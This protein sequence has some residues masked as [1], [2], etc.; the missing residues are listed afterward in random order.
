MLKKSFIIIITL[1]TCS[2]ALKAQEQ[3][4]DLSGNAHLNAL[5]NK[6]ITLK[7]PHIYKQP[8]A[9]NKILL[10]L[11][12][13]D[14]FSQNWHF[15][16]QNLWQDIQVYVN[17]NYPINPPSYGVATFDG[18]DSTG[19]PYDF[20]SSTSW[21]IADSLTSH[22]IDLTTI[23]DSV[24]LSFQYQPQGNGNAPESG[25]SL[26]LDFF[27]K[28]DSTW[29][30][31]W[32][33]GGSATQSF[34]KVMVPVG[35]DFHNDE[36]Q[37]RFSNLSTLS[38]NFDHWHIDYIYL[39]DNRT[40]ADTLLDDVA[41]T[42]NFYNLLNE[43]TAM[44]WDHYLTDTI[45]LMAETMPVT[46]K[47]NFNSSYDVFYKYEV[48]DN[49]GSGPMV[50]VYPSGVASKTV[51]PYSSLTEPQAV[52]QI[53][54][55]FLNDFNFP[56]DNSNNKVFEIKNYFDINPFIDINQQNDTARAYQ[57]FGNYYAYD[58]GSAEL[59]YGIEGVTA[60]LANQF[61]IK[62]ADTLTA[63]SIYFNPILDNISGESFK[64]TVWSSLNPEVIVYQQ[65][66]FYYPSYSA[67]N[68]MV[69]FALGTP[70]ILNPGVYYF[71]YQ[72]ITNSRLNVGYDVNTSNKNKIWYN[73]FGNWENPSGGI[74]NGSLMIHPIFGTTGNPV[75]S[76]S[77]KTAKESFDN[78]LIYPNPTTNFVTIINE[79]NSDL[80]ELELM[81]MYGKT[82][83]KEQFFQK[84]NL[85]LQHLSKGIYFVRII[86][87]STQQ[88][89]IKKLI[90]Q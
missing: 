35:T 38:G 40:F 25:D 71:G 80:V 58:D 69:E 77:E 84:T 48:I 8:T 15:P 26:R 54:P 66:D 32:Q 2:V 11:P 59:G 43:F 6:S 36:F 1:L 72:K 3:L 50:E 85:N 46:Y 45:G 37:F 70:V 17:S 55:N 75:V 42:T 14:D 39:N 30:R 21:G 19:Y 82:V 7:Q 5:Y 24:Y 79:T 68:Q 16:N 20:S 51:A 89:S 60:K 73:V 63:I 90:L 9:T 62:K 44:P 53:A 83:A 76:I 13:I 86:S 22:P 65:P 56:S 4:Y 28:A 29:I 61:H 57:V 18:L 87:H 52:Y 31:V 34:K 23:N 10:T 88:I 64:L 74:P 27:R 81:D 49:N 12:F 47:N 78:W 33:V 67:T 41:L